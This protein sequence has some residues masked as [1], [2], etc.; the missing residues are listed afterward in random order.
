MAN[1]DDD[2]YYD[3]SI[4]ATTCDDFEFIPTRIIVIQMI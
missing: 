3:Y 4:D 1:Y 2:D